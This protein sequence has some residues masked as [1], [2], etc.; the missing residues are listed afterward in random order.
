MSSSEEFIHRDAAHV[1]RA[2]A[3]VAE[4]TVV[5]RAKGALLWDPEGK[6]YVDCSSGLFTVNVGHCHPEVVAAIKEQ[7]EKVMQ[8]S[9]LQTTE[10]LVK[11]AELLAEM[12]PGDLNKAYYTNGGTESIDTA[13]KCVRLLTGKY[14]VI[15][16]KNAFHGLTGGALAAT[17][18]V[19]YHKGFGPLE[20]GFLRA[21]HAYCYRCPFNMTYPSCDLR[22]AQEIENIITDTAISTVSEGSIG[23]LLVEPVQG[24]GG[25]IPP[26]AWLPRLREICTKHGVLLVVDEIQTGFGRTGKL[27]ACDHGNVVP[28]VFVIAKNVGGGIPAGMVMLNDER[29]A[30]IQ[31]GTTPTHSGNALA[32]AAGYAAA[33]V[34]LRE[35][36]WENAAA[37][38]KRF[39]ESFLNAPMSRYVGQASFK[40][41]M[42]GVELVL[43][44]KTKQPV[45]KDKMNQIKLGLHERGVVI[46]FS[47]PMG[48]IFRIQPTLVITPLQVDRVVAA[49]DD[50]VTQ[51]LGKD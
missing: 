30:K 44:K 6:E 34:L 23:A 31:T 33:K 2:W 17:G 20:H 51:V 14:E 35:K 50:T 27:W 28:D 9:I 36:L 15:V 12:A 42:G 39:S 11:H 19:S 5:A 48:N 26:D 49:F 1:I 18:G 41:L 10:A 25:I 4:P 3:G 38:G 8:V 29:A 32:T 24:R 7:A 22:C 16:L 43:D 45:P 40:G 13:L 46:S 21:P 47:G 37:M